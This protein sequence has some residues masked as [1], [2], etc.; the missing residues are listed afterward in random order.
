MGGQRRCIAASH[1]CLAFARA[2]EALFANLPNPFDT[3][4]NVIITGTSSGLGRAT[5]EVL[6]N[7]GKWHVI[8]VR[9]PSCALRSLQRSGGRLHLSCAPRARVEPAPVCTRGSAGAQRALRSRNAPP[10][11]PAPRPR[12]SLAHAPAGRATRSARIGEPDTA[13]ATAARPE[14]RCGACEEAQPGF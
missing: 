8:M 4:K 2:Q 10:Y 13:S 6:C 3:R 14:R 7:S 1:P 11:L 5:A 9:E 12:W